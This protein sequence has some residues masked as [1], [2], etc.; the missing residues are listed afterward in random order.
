[1][2]VYQGEKRMA[3]A[4]LRVLR[5]RIGQPYACIGGLIHLPTRRPRWLIPFHTPDDTAQISFNTC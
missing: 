2:T 1:M 5:E 3:V 4:W